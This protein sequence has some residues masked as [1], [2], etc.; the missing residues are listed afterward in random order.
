MQTLCGHCG[1]TVGVD[2]HPVML[3]V[4]ADVTND[5]TDCLQTQ[6][7]ITGM[8]LCN[9]Q[10]PYLQV[11]PSTRLSLDADHTN[12]PYSTFKNNLTNNILC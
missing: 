3:S 4:E 6:Q 5:H 2:G 8:I 7:K 9:L 11:R 10:V 1:P 12:Q